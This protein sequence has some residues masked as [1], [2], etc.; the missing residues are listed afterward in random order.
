MAVKS[1][2]EV[3]NR[4]QKNLTNDNSAFRIIS[5]EGLDGTEVT[6]PS[7]DLSLGAL[8]FDTTETNLFKVN[9]VNI[10]FSVAVTE[11]VT[12]TKTTT[13][14]NYSEV[15]ASQN[16]TG[17]TSIRFIS[18]SLIDSVVNPDDGEQFSITCTNVGLSGIAY[19]TLN[20]SYL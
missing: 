5:G 2:T 13:D 11:T 7:Q 3:Q 6:V 1:V 9:Y 18:N 16:T 15:V 20:I 19:V 12:L 10:N 8:S 17:N 4:V 14:P